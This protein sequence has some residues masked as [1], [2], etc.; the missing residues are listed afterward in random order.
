M[1]RYYPI[2]A[3]ALL[4]LAVTACGGS[5]GTGPDDEDDGSYFYRFD[6]NGTR[7]NYTLQT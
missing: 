6:A 7:V 4:I 1:D 5:D 2:R 3:V